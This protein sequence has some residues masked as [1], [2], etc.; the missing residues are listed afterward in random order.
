MTNQSV[1][2]YV[3]DVTSEV[4]EIAKSADPASSL[5]DTTNFNNL[6]PGTYY[7]SLGDTGSYNN[8]SRVL[9]QSHKIV[10]CEPT[11]AWSDTKKGFSEMKRWTEFLV[12]RFCSWTTVEFYTPVPAL[13]DLQLELADTRKINDPQLWI[14]GCSISHGV[15]V[16]DSEK[17]GTLLSASLNMPVSF[18]TENGSS[19]IWAK[20][21]ICR[22]DI[23]AGD[24]VVWGLTQ[25]MRFPYYNGYLHHVVAGYYSQHPYFNNTIPMTELSSK[26]TFYRAMTSIHQ[27]IQYC[28][29][30]DAKLVLCGM[31]VDDN[32]LP[33]LYNLPNYVQFYGYPEL[34]EGKRFLDLGTDSQHPGPVTH[35]WYADTILKKLKQ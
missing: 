11:T 6:L 1:T 8:L 2:V 12:Q 13:D 22:S 14:A 7:T 27:V 3:G 16:D 26:N 4:A 21:Q 17:Y 33:W 28:K 30:V 9:A 31:L 23:R 5:I 18:L 29:K 19:I 24:I 32:F 20:D 10:Y 15:G 35:Q 25:A 34:S